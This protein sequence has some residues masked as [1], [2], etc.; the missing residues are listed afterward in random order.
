MNVGGTL[1]RTRERIRWH[2]RRGLLELDLVL[3]AFLE[4]HFD[5]LDE[6]GLD[7]FGH[8]L[9]R[10]DPELLDL[11]M[12]REETTNA[13]EREIVALLRAESCNALHQSI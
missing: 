7:A 1:D 10:P 12:G 6:A 8:L 13:R 5:N 11:V 4:T 3:K 9:T 2:C